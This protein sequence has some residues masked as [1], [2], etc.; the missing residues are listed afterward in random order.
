LPSFE[1]EVK[2]RVGKQAQRQA[3]R[4]EQWW[5]E[6]RPAVG[7]LFADELERTFRLLRELPGAGVR[8]PT[9]RRPNLR[10]VLMPNTGNHVYY[11]VD[12][13]T[14]IVHVVA[15]WGAPRGRRPKL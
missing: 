3:T 8:W 14:Q 10:R 15:V 13:A 12:Q 11:Q 9:A 6:H 1:R 4:I 2:L 5:G 7:S